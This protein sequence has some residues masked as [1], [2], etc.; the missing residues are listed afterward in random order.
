M[1]MPIIAC[2]PENNDKAEGGVATNFF[3]PARVIAIGR[4]SDD[5]ATEI[6]LDGGSEIV[7]IE[8][9]MTPREVMEAISA[10]IPARPL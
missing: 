1:D 2:V 5:T 9:P 10:C 7:T 3:A 4:N 8:T 6:L